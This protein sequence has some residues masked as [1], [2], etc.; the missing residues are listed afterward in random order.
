MDLQKEKQKIHISIHPHTTRPLIFNKIFP[1]NEIIFVGIKT[2]IYYLF[3]ER[4]LH[5][6]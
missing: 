3:I 2:H 4:V 5:F 6:I 1:S